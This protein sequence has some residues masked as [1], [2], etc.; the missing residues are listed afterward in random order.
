MSIVTIAIIIVAAFVAAVVR[1]A[2]H[3]GDPNNPYNVRDAVS[4]GLALLLF[5]LIVAA[6]PKV[7]GG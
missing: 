3:K 6:G 1:F 4:L 2:A 7:L 5:G